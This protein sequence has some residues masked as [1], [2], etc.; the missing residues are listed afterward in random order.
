MHVISRKPILAF[1]EKHPDAGP[2][3]RHWY[4]VAIAARWASIQDVRMTFPAA[5]A[6]AVRSN[7]TVT[8]FN[9]G[10]NKYRLVAAIHYNRGRLYVLRIMTHA[11]YQ[12]GTWKDAL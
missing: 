7:R 6:V 11:Q 4:R 3:L 8:V 5:D 10:G 1:A 12:K 9:I 2:A